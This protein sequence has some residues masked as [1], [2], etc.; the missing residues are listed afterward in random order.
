MSDCYV[1][2]PWADDEGLLFAARAF[3]RRKAHAGPYDDVSIIGLEDLHHVKN[4]DMLYISGHSGQGLELIGGTKE[5]RMTA[6]E[7]AAAVRDNNLNR[8]HKV[9]KLWACYSGDGLT[10]DPR[11]GL[12]YRFWESIKTTHK[13]LTVYGYRYATVDPFSKYSKS[14]SGETLPGFKSMTETPE[15]WKDLPGS[16][17]HWRVGIRPDGTLVPPKPLPRAAQDAEDDDSY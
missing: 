11:H 8:K 7:L 12:A 15:L 1:C 17:Q 13:A 6:G 4:D 10:D 2:L 5:Q 16:A 9:I 14:K 3:A